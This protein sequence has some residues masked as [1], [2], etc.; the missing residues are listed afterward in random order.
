MRGNVSIRKVKD[1]QQNIKLL[2]Q[3]I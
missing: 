1:L 3:E 2:Q